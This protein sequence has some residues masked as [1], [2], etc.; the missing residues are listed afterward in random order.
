MTNVLFLALH[1]AVANRPAQLRCELGARIF[2]AVCQA[3]ELSAS[4]SAADGLQADPDVTP[5]PE[6]GL[7]F[8]RTGSVSRT[9]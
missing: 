2:H 6:A 5:E 1:P 4:A 9:G 8:S 7:L 3:E